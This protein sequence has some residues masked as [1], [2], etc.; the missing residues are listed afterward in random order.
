MS[1]GRKQTW[2]E[3]AFGSSPAECDEDHEDM[4]EEQI[5][6]SAVAEAIAA[7][8]NDKDPF[9]YYHFRCLMP[10]EPEEFFRGMRYNS[11]RVY[12]EEA[13]HMETISYQVLDKTSSERVVHI[14]P[15]KKCPYWLQ[16]VLPELNF[17]MVSRLG[18]PAY[19]TTVRGI[20]PEIPDAYYMETVLAPAG[21]EPTFEMAMPGSD[22]KRV[23][24]PLQVF[25]IDITKDYWKD[26]KVVA[27]KDPSQTAFGHM[28]VL[29]DGWESRDAKMCVHKLIRMVRPGGILKPARSTVERLLVE[30][31]GKELADNVGRKVLHSIPEWYH[32]T[33]GEIMAERPDSDMGS[34]SPGSP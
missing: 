18:F 15:I 31:I 5:D 16:K 30:G 3:W 20:R 26:G 32:L 12:K 7:E 9:N 19:K 1:G 17:E 23:K 4:G 13:A 10:L 8:A 25:D 2:G 28:P 22:G 34:A 14:K 24:Y 11:T 6:E 21:V 29:T 33:L 27:E